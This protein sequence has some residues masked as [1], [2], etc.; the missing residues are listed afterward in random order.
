[1][2]VLSTVFAIAMALTA[3]NAL[4][5][6]KGG[7]SS[8]NTGVYGVAGCGLGSIVFGNQPGAMQVVAATLNGT[9]V[10]TFGITTGTSNCGPGLFAQR[11]TDFVKSNKVALQN[12]IS[13]GQGETLA[14]FEQMLDC[15]NAGFAQ[16]LKS[17]FETIFAQTSD[18][19]LAQ[20]M[21]SHCR[22]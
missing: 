12:D 3:Q 16:D 21:V 15:K 7:M 14:S 20:A 5:A 9:G 8:T 6:P 11:V 22:I 2:K 18:Q 4:A 10:Q 17:N 1:M 13:K 19:D